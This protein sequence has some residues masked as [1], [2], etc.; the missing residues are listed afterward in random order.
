MAVTTPSMKDLINNANTIIQASI[1]ASSDS[2]GDIVKIHKGGGFPPKAVF[3]VIVLGADREKRQHKTAAQTKPRSF[4]TALEWFIAVV[5][6]TGDLEESFET[7]VDIWDELIPIID[8]NHTWNDLV[9]DTNYRGDI[10][11][12][13]PDFGDRSFL[14]YAIMCPLVSNVYF[15]GNP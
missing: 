13:A 14:T 9:H 4:G 6:S 7:A 2:L 12:G 8:T 15:G 10:E 5:T 3:P 11:F 1:D